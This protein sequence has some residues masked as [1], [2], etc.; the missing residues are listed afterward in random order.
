MNKVLKILLLEDEPQEIDALQNCMNNLEHFD[1]SGITA[2]AA[3]A[4]ELIVSDCPDAVIVVLTV[5]FCRD[6]DP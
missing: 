3:E 6:H 1:L 5:C 4:L 2:D